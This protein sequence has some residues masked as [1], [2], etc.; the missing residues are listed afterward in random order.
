MDEKVTARV[1]LALVGEAP[2]VR[3]LGGILTQGLDELEIE[4]LPADLIAS[5]EVNVE[6][7]VAFNDSISVS[8]LKVPDAVTVLSD[9]D[10]MVAKVEPPRLVEAEEELL[11]AAAAVSAEP[12]VLTEARERAEAQNKEDE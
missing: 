4:C 10:S 1:P 9:P 2:G 12:E 8:D 5:I 3:E 7:L 6:G 11:E